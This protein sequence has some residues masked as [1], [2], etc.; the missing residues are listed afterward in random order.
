MAVDRG[1][2]GQQFVRAA[3]L[4]GAVV[5]ENKGVMVC[6]K[7]H[8]V[9]SGSSMPLG[10]FSPRMSAT[11]RDDHAQCLPCGLRAHRFGH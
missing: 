3:R 1:D 10:A 2:G 6:P 8:M 4:A 11:R 7:A 9:D 5:G